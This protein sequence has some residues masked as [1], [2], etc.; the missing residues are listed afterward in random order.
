MKLFRK[1]IKEKDRPDKMSGDKGKKRRIKACHNLLGQQLRCK[2]ITGTEIVSEPLRESPLGSTVHWYQ[3][4]GNWRGEIL[5]VMEKV[6]QF[7]AIGD[8]TNTYQHQMILESIGATT[9]ENS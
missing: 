5:K 3:L 6:K 7:K 9:L 4:V 1:F 2:T 8:S